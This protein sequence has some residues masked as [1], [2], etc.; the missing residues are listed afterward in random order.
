MIFRPR[1]RQ[2]VHGLA[3]PALLGEQPSQVKAANVLAY[4]FDAGMT[5]RGDLRKREGSGGLFQEGQD[6]DP[7]VTGKPPDN[8]RKGSKR[9]QGSHFGSIANPGDNR[10]FART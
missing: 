2:I 4:R 1:G 9:E 6:R 5:A 7:A 8:S 10:T 3:P